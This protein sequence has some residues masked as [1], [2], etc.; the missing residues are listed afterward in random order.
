[1]Y[2]ILIERHAEKDLQKLPKV[3]VHDLA[4]KIQRLCEDPRPIGSTKLQGTKNSWRVRSGLYRVLYDIDDQAKQIK[5]YRIKH[6]KDAY[7]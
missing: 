2:Q 7:R 6:R 1:M 4:D 5:V 3:V